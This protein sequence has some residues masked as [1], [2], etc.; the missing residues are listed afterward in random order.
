[1][2]SACGDMGELINNRLDVKGI[3]SLELKQEKLD[4]F[5][6]SNQIDLLQLLKIKISQYSFT[7]RKGPL[8]SVLK[9]SIFTPSTSGEY[10]IKVTDMKSKAE[11]IILI[12][13]YEP[14]L[15]YNFAG[16]TLTGRYRG[17]ADTSLLSFN[18][19]SAASYFDVNSILKTSP[20]NF[21][22]LNFE[23]SLQSL[24]GLLIEQIGKNL[25]P[26]SIEFATNWF[27]DANTI[28]TGGFASAPDNSPTAT[29]IQ[30]T[31]DVATF[32]NS[33]L[34]V[35]TIG[36]SYVASIFAKATS[37]NQYLTLKLVGSDASVRRWPLT[38]KWQRYSLSGKQVD[39]AGVSIT[40]DNDGNGGVP[41]PADVLVW[42]AQLEEGT[43]AT[44]FIPTFGAAAG[45][46]ADIALVS[47]NG[48]LEENKGTLVIEWDVPQVKSGDNYVLGL[49]APIPGNGAIPNGVYL[50]KSTS[51]NKTSIEVYDN[52][53]RTQN[54]IGQQ[55]AW[56]SESRHKVAISY[57]ESEIR[58]FENGQFAGSLV[59]KIPSGISLMSL[60]FSAGHGADSY[61]N[62]HIKS[63]KYFPISGSDVDL[64]NMSK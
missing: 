31:A 17:A 12:N 5:L 62:G 35:G 46:S 20:A 48:W 21:P 24:R 30:M 9:N 37:T 22:R 11:A 1:M 38:N 32:L 58:F 7:M 29:R 15:E 50:F 14:L 56:L 27:K 33:P 42:G 3:G 55:S 51:T 28:V 25:M 64:Q 10:E 40:V 63:L 34:Y 41:E 16:G 36:T 6:Q 2:T 60:G 47:Q 13:V 8:A 53:I 18:R 23:T 52:G 45:R 19:T 44:S 4:L 57:T 54:L 59:A 39:Q 26:V 49:S 61:L 43:V